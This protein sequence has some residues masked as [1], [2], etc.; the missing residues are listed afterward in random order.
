[1]SVKGV[2]FIVEFALFVTDYAFDRFF[3]KN[4]FHLNPFCVVAILDRD[5]DKGHAFGSDG[6][7]RVW[8]RHWDNEIDRWETILAYICVMSEPAHIK[9]LLLVWNAR[10]I[11]V[12]KCPVSEIDVC[13]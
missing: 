9:P 3:G 13:S 4:P 5:Y 6:T 2:G 1:M 11:L 7:V 10:V 12:D 8:K